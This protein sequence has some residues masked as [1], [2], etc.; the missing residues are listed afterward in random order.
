MNKNIGFTL[1]EVMVMLTIMAIVM[2]MGMPSFNALLKSNRQVTHTNDLLIALNFARSEAVNRGQRVVACILQ[3]GIA[4]KVCQTDGTNSW[5]T[6]W[7]I[8]VDLNNDAILQASAG[9]TILRVHDPLDAGDTVQSTAFSNYISYAP[10]GI[11][12]S[13]NN[14]TPLTGSFNFSLCHARHKN[15]VQINLVGRPGVVR[16]APTC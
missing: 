9:E 12:R 10:D 11:V 16:P 3:R 8:F 13:I 2:V 1:I 6:G 15:T 5:E 7:M 14:G 4:T